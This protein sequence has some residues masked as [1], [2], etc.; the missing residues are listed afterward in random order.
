LS[1]KVAA[2]V[3]LQKQSGKHKEKSHPLVAAAP[4]QPIT[5]KHVINERIPVMV[6][7]KF[8]EIHESPSAW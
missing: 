8:Q 2:L 7:M 4:A 6:V 5:I 1:C 3:G